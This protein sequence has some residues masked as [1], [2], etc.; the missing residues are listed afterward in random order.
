VLAGAT[1]RIGQIAHRGREV[2]QFGR[3]FDVVGRGQQF[4]PRLA[5]GAFDQGLPQADRLLQDR[6][7][8]GGRA[9]VVQNSAQVA[10]RRCQ[11]KRGIELGG[12]A[13]SFDEGL[14]FVHRA[15]RIAPVKSVQACCRS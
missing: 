14:E 12:V 2:A 4:F 1:Q 8:L 9:A 11:L 10:D 7:G 13:E 15:L 5:P 6:D 3:G